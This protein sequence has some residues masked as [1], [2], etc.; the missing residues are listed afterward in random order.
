V[1]DSSGSIN[2]AGVGNYGRLKEFLINVVQNR[3][4]RAVGPT[5][6]QF[7]LVKYSNAAVVYFPLNQYNNVN[8]ITDS[9]RQLP[10][11]D[12]R[13][14]ITGALRETRLNVFQSGLG[15]RSNAPNVLILIS[16]G[17]PND[18]VGGER[19]EAN[20]VK[21]MGTTIVTVGITTAI[22]RD[23]MN[24]MSSTGQLIESSTFNTDDLNRIVGN[25][26]SAACAGDC[27]PN[28]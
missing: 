11:D 8:D 12:G 3:A 7:A 2:K 1:V 5:G 22:D 17:T 21:D 28:L 24:D 9:I 14:N 25:L 27:W 19:D 18:E 6:V 26:A 4:F 16:D 20:R 10:Y 15:D 23:L 13:T